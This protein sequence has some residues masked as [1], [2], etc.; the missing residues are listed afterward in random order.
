M[1][2]AADQCS[3][4]IYRKDSPLDLQK[5][6]AEIADPRMTGFSRD[7]VSVIA[8]R[9]IRERVAGASGIATRIIAQRGRSP[10][11]S[12]SL[13]WSVGQGIM[14]MSERLCS[15]EGCL[16]KH[17]AKRFC[18]PHYARMRKGQSLDQPIQGHGPV[19]FCSVEGCE[20]KH[21]GKASAV[22][23]TQE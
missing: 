8:S 6:E 22:L 11:G 1:Q 17:Y 10:S 4:C 19:K 20:R 14:S 7:I 2:V 12:G 5:L 21:K 3:T 23:T 9:T 16:R 13:R 15:V 18:E